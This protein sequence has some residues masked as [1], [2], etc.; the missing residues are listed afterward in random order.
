MHSVTD[1][2]LRVGP[3]AR[4]LVVGAAQGKSITNVLSAAVQV[5][6]VSGSVVR[7]V[8]VTAGVTASNLELADRPSRVTARI[9]RTSRM[10]SAAPIHTRTRPTDGP[11]FEGSGA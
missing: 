2:P 6:Q 10:T 5:V 7:L 4:A 9:G 8:G 1:A 11:A 3:V